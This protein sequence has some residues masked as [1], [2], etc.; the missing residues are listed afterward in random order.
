MNDNSH[1]FIDYQIHIE[2]RI[3]LYFL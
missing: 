2:I 3:N 1:S